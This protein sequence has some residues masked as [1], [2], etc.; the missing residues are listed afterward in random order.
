MVVKLCPLPPL[1]TVHMPT[2]YMYVDMQQ[3]Y[4]DA[5]S[6]SNKLILALKWD[7]CCIILTYFFSSTYFVDMQVSY[8]YVNMQDK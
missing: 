7:L 1:H 6:T 4:V 5:F 2:K 8:M 3:N